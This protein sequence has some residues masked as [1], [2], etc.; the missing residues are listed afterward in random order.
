M[1]RPAVFVIVDGLLKKDGI[2]VLIAQEQRVSFGGNCE[3]VHLPLF[4]RFRV[5]VVAFNLEDRARLVSVGTEFHKTR[6]N[7]IYLFRDNALS[8]AWPSGISNG[9]PGQGTNP[10]FSVATIAIESVS[11]MT[12]VP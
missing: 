11:S 9:P 1:L 7:L 10:P 5:V 3:A 4:A 6:R 12:Y 2:A 8:T